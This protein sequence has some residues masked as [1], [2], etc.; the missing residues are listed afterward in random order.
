LP[1]LALTPSPP[2]FHP[3]A[4]RIWL[5]FSTLNSNLVFFDRKRGGL[6]RK[7]AVA[8]LGMLVRFR[9]GHHRHFSLKQFRAIQEGAASRRVSAFSTESNSGERLLRQQYMPDVHGLCAMATFMR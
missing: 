1:S 9:P 8:P 2:F 6:L 4:S 7:F 5:A 3:A